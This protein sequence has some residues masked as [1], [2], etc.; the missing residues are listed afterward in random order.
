MLLK[1]ILARTKFHYHKVHYIAKKPFSRRVTK[2]FFYLILALPYNC[3]DWMNEPLSFFVWFYVVVLNFVM[4]TRYERTKNFLTWREHERQVGNWLLIDTKCC[5]LK[6]TQDVVIVAIIAFSKQQACKVGQRRKFW[7]WG[8]KLIV[9][10]CFVFNVYFNQKY[11]VRKTDLYPHIDNQESVYLSFCDSYNDITDDLTKNDNHNDIMAFH[12]LNESHRYIT[13][14]HTKSYNR[15][16]ITAHLTNNGSHNNSTVYLSFYSHI[17]NFSC[18]LCTY[19]F[20]IRIIN[21]MSLNYLYEKQ[22]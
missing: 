9:W 7:Y 6:Q 17:D 11:G 13:A 20:L 2:E 5:S 8:K 22:F 12:A 14:Y 3:S 1:D 15:K 4:H 21:M 16:N 18:S 10:Y 19:T